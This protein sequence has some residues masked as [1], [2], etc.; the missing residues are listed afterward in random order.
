MVRT[1]AAKI[2]ELERKVG[3]L[4]MELDL[5]K[6]RGALGTPA[7]TLSHQFN[8]ERPKDFSVAR[9][10]RTMKLVRS[11]LSLPPRGGAGKSSAR[12]HRQYLRGIPALRLEA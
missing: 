3:P 6:K 5:L 10:C 1:F 12:A 7:P 4:T 2:A 11:T 8:R 9:G